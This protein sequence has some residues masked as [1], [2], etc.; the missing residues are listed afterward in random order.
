MLGLR[1]AL[2]LGAVLAVGAGILIGVQ[3][4]EKARREGLK[5]AARRLG[6]AW[7]PRDE[8]VPGDGLERLPL[9]QVGRRRR[10][11]SV[12]RG[13]IAGRETIAFDW[14]YVT[15]SGQHS[16]RHRL[17]IAAFRVPGTSLPAFQVRPEN[18]FH[19]MGSALGWQ[20][21]DFDRDEEFSSKFLL[22]GSDEAAIRSFF[23]R[24]IRRAF[25]RDP[26][27]NAD[28]G[29]EWIALWRSRRPSDDDFRGHLER[30]GTIARLLGEG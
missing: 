2:L 11:D 3:R 6:L 23:T 30:A 26:G 16:S 20:D 9:F 24:E 5:R 13:E 8:A 7:E 17:T 28:C 10:A 19:K 14:T 25:T 21:I 1:E 12:M 27:W 18:L 4:R 29:G 22:R 15:G